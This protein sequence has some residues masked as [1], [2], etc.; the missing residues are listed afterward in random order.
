MLGAPAATAQ[1]TPRSADDQLFFPRIRN[2]AKWVFVFLAIVFAL[3]LRRLR[4]RHR[5]LRHRRLFRTSSAGR[6]AGGAVDLERREED[7]QGSPERRAGASA[8][9]RRALQND[10]TVDEAIA[11]LASVRRLRPKDDIDALQRARGALPP[12]GPTRSARAT[13]ARSRLERATSR[14]P[15]LPTSSRRR[16][17]RRSARSRPDRPRRSEQTHSPAHERRLHE[18]AGTAYAKA[19]GGLQGDRQAQAATTR[20]PAPARAGGGGGERVPTAI[21]AYKTFL[22]LAPDDPSRSRRSKQRVEAAEELRRTCDS[23]R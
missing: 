7:G 17:A 15:T 8:I 9:S 6:A 10:G 3:E 19:V 2:Q 22:K 13:A 5:R 12:P 18:D 4:R 11:P 16:S 20:R 14:E 21:A 1:S 23:R